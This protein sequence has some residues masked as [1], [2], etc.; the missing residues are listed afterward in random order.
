MWDKLVHN[1]LLPSAREHPWA[2]VE[3]RNSAL[4]A[5]PVPSNCEVD[6]PAKRFELRCTTQ[7]LGL[8]P[9]EQGLKQER[10]VMSSSALRSRLAYLGSDGSRP[11]PP[12][13]VEANQTSNHGRAEGPERRHGLRRQLG[14]FGR[15]MASCDHELASPDPAMRAGQRPSYRERRGAIAP[16]LPRVVMLHFGAMTAAHAEERIDRPIGI[17]TKSHARRTLVVADH[18]AIPALARSAACA[19]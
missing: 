16:D 5:C 17:R 15:P 4:I 6:G 10:S 13:I 7:W 14:I 11:A 18:S 1:A 19:P 3:F 8:S 9:T 12:G 2:P